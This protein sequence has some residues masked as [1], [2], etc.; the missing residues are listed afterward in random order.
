M[1]MDALD[2]RVASGQQ[3]EPTLDERTGSSF[4]KSE[5]EV[6][7]ERITKNA[8]ADL[9]MTTGESRRQHSK[10]NG[11]AIVSEIADCVT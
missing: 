5:G 11:A 6:F 1:S 8:L 3:P 7:V 4:S 10:C 9:Q 2:A